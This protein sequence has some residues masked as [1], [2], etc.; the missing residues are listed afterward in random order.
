MKEILSGKYPSEKYR[1]IIKQL[2]S[3]IDIPGGPDST[4]NVPDDRINSFIDKI[5]SRTNKCTSMCCNGAFIVETMLLVVMND[6][7]K[8]LVFDPETMKNAWKPGDIREYVPFNYPALL[9][10]YKHFITVESPCSEEFRSLRP[11]ALE[12]LKIGR[13][14]LLLSQHKG[15]KV[16]R[17]HSNTREYLEFMK[18]LGPQWSW[19]SNIWEPEHVLVSACDWPGMEMRGYLPNAQHAMYALTDLFTPKWWRDATFE[20]LTEI[21]LSNDFV[22][23]FCEN[24]GTP[25]FSAMGHACPNLKVLDLSGLIRLRGESILYLFF[26]DAF[27]ILHEFMYIHRYRYEYD[28]ER[29]YGS[30]YLDHTNISQVEQHSFSR[31]CPW[32]VD[33]GVTNWL[34]AGCEFNMVVFSVI[35]TR[36]TGYLY[37]Y[38]KPFKFYLGP[39]RRQEFLDPWLKFCSRLK[40]YLLINHLSYFIFT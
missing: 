14:D 28:S 37:L 40:A 34:R 38:I 29:E 13:F 25:L 35:D 3:S 30:I 7:I 18:Y 39:A 8:E 11:I 26:H 31:Y 19:D 6:E 12:K 32:C 2:P 17:S 33:E 9:A 21:S 27:Q 16:L 4:S 5:K 24:E 20:K 15:Y 10:S 23:N 1:N 22:T 36:N